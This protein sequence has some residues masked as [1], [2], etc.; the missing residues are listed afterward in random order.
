MKENRW[1]PRC[2]PTRFP[3]HIRDLS[4]SHHQFDLWT[5]KPQQCIGKGNP[6]RQ[7][8]AATVCP[9]GLIVALSVRCRS[10]TE[11]ACTVCCT[12]VL[13]QMPAAISN[14][15]FQVRSGKIPAGCLKC[16]L[17][18]VLT[19]VMPS[20]HGGIL[21]KVPISFD[22]VSPESTLQFPL[23][24]PPHCSLLWCN[25]YVVPIWGQ[26]LDSLILLAYTFSQ[27]TYHPHQLVLQNS[28]WE[29]KRC[30]ALEMAT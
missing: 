29:E 10:D 6:A 7:C 15:A 5:L 12:S 30:M 26:I 22:L 1:I 13:Q 27:K 23:P 11:V 3:D 16:S 2:P 17:I 8:S 21:P 20:Q 28:W 25:S 19:S 18:P 14:P 4:S 24:S 9:A